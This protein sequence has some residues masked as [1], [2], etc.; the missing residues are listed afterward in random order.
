MTRSPARRLLLT[1]FVLAFPAL[2]A[3]GCSG[4]KKPP[5]PAED[6]APPPPVDAAPLELAPLDDDAGDADTDA[7][8]AGPKWGT[9]GVGPNDNQRKILACCAAIQAQ[10]AHLQNGPEQFQLNNMAAACRTLAAQVGPGG[11]APE[12][13]QL[14]ALL[15]TTKI[16]I[17]C[18]L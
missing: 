7:Y 3:Y 15:S 8:E 6:A 2:A 11:N 4:C 14:R 13:A 18:G 1:T 12:F 17:S 9:G 10:A 5:P 16:P